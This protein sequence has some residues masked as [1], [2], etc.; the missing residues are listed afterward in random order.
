MGSQDLPRPVYQ[1]AKT[2]NTA[3]K[4]VL[5]QY[6]NEVTEPTIQQNRVQ[7]RLNFDQRLNTITLKVQS[8][9]D[10]VVFRNIRVPASLQN[11]LPLVAG[12][13]PVE[14]TYNYQ[15]DECDHV[16]TADCSQNRNH[17][18]LAKEVNGLKHVTIYQG[19]DQIELRPAQAYSN[20]VDNWKLSVNGQQ[21][22]LQ[23]NQKITL[24]A[25]SVLERI[26]AHWTNDNTV[27]INT[28]QVR[29]VH[30]GKT[31]TVEVNNT[32]NGSQCGL[33]GDYNMDRGTDVLSSKGCIMSSVKLAAH[34]YRS[35]S[36]Q[37]RPISEKTLSQI[38]TE[39]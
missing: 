22:Q 30:Q 11:V 16:I 26:T 12:Q 15:V 17:A 4:A 31:V 5:F 27:V 38:R 1:L 21:V 35:K 19:Q 7:V 33:C 28:P 25:S 34:T 37:C 29:L 8:P 10:N 2:L 20:R 6:L 39:E 23:K 9:Q 18:V 32:P 3:A 14:Q 13:N 24:R 36:E